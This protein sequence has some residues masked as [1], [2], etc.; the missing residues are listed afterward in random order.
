MS[1]GAMPLDL[2]TA[3]TRAVL[4]TQLA[5]DSHLGRPE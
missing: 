1:S 4:W 3:V 5:E 2:S